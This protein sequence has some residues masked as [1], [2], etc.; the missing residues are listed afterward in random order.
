VRT[1][2]VALAYTS[3]DFNNQAEIVLTA[4]S[5]IIESQSQEVNGFGTLAFIVR[6]VADLDNP[7]ITLEAVWQSTPGTFN[8]NRRAAE[9]LWQQALQLNSAYGQT[10]TKSQHVFMRV[11]NDDAVDHTLHIH[12]LLRV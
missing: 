4:G 2:Q 11:R 12:M 8:T 5:Q 6:N 9:I 7:P 3:W 10:T 1:K